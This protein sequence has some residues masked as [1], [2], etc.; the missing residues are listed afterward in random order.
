MLTIREKS[1]NPV[2]VNLG[3]GTIMNPGGLQE[4]NSSKDKQENW[5]EMQI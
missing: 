4:L 5:W 1:S 3:G 2:K